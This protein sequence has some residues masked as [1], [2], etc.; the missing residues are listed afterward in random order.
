M[1]RKYP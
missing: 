1:T